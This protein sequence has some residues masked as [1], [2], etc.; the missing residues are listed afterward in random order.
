MTIRQPGTLVIEY[1]YADERDCAT[2]WSWATPTSAS[3]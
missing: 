3:T 2:R 1:T